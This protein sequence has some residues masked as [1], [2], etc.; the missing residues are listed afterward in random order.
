MSEPVAAY[1]ETARALAG[2]SSV[3]ICAHVDPDGDAIGSTLGLTHVLRRLG[4]DAVPALAEDRDTPDTYAFLPGFHLLKQ[5]AELESPA[6]FVALDTPNLGRLGDAARLAEGARTRIVIDH[7]PDNTGYG[8]VNLVD[9][10]AAAVGQVVWRLLPLLDL[11]PDPDIALCLYVA[12]LT[13]TGRFQYSN[14]DS[15]VLRDAAA[16]VDIGVDIHAVH[17]RIYENQ[18][19]GHIEIVGLVKSRIVLANGGRVAYSWVTEEDFIRTGATQEST[20]NLVDAIRVIGGV[21]IV[22]LAKTAGGTCRVSLRAKGHGDVGGVARHFGGGGH[23]A[24][25]G[26]SFGCDL[27]EL[28]PQLLPLL[29]GA[30]VR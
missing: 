19:L 13:D 2:A 17:E 18:S 16:M 1:V 26:F 24:A 27:D 30:E 28:L 22:F 25:A 29:P 21:D 4:I 23:A 6:V 11:P 20:E 15:G 14:S 12:L 5:P 3:V 8:E 9:P 7:H 10:A